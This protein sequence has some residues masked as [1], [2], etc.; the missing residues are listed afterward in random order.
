MLWRHESV[1]F[2][3]WK[4]FWK[5]LHYSNMPHFQQFS[6]SFSSHTSDQMTSS[7]TRIYSIMEKRSYIISKGGKT[8][9]ILCDSKLLPLASWALKR[10][11]PDE[12]HTGIGCTL[13][14]YFPLTWSCATYVPWL[15]LTGIHP[16]SEQHFMIPIN[17][18]DFWA[19]HHP[20]WLLLYQSSVFKES[21]LSSIILE[22]C[23]KWATLTVGTT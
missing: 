23:W 8:V 21:N 7:E 15:L 17:Q 5:L 22:F 6:S 14:W 12:D 11:H 18:S 13:D 9:Q 10:S 20:S 19:W 1:R 3:L 16:S 4:Q 2:R